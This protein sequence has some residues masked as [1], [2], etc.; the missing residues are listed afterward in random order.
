MCL[1]HRVYSIENTTFFV[2]VGF[3]VGLNVILRCI[4]FVDWDSPLSMFSL[5]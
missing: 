1:Q 5:F 3:R 4:V 2:F